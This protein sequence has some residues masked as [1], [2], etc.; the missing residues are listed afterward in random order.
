MRIV[1]TA[2]ALGLLA[3][4]PA[5]SED[6]AKSPAPAKQEESNESSMLRDI[7]MNET[8]QGLRIP[9]SGPDG[10]LIMLLD[11]KSARRVDEEHVEMDNLRI[12]FADDDGKTFVVTMPV[13]TF[14]LTNRVL[15]GN[16]KVKIER[17]DFVIDGD[18]AEFDTRNR[19]GK[20][21]GNV[22]MLIFNTQ[23]L[24]NE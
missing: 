19:L 6:A 12:E 5:K 17:E 9:H 16:Q 21:T 2:F 22:K 7:P 10:K 14:N 1:I 23:N 24:E 13:A 18:G 15:T 8:F 11:T 4:A 20:V 3:V